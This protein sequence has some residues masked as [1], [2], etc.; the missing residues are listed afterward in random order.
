MVSRS[1][2]KKNV[3]F[4]EVASAWLLMSCKNTP[5]WDQEKN[6]FL[7]FL[8]LPNLNSLLILFISS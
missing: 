1:N 3:N 4:F 8:S 6:F 7:L 2:F 5:A